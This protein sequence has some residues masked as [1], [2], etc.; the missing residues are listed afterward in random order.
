[1]LSCIIIPSSVTSVGR[2]AFAGNGLTNITIGANVD[3]DYN[4][5]EQS[6][7]DDF[8]NTYNSGGKQAGTYTRPDNDSVEW[9]RQ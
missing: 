2:S 1:M 8:V 6:D 4:F 9:T 5:F 3:L 7:W